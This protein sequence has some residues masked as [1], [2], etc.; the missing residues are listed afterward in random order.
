M[1]TKEEILTVINQLPKVDR[2]WIA[3]NIAKESTSSLS[4]MA[5]VRFCDV[6]REL[7][8]ETYYWTAKDAGCMNILLKKIRAKMIEAGSACEDNEV[9]NTME[10]YIRQAYKVDPWIADHYNVANLNSQFNNLYNK[11]KYGTQQANNNNRN[12]LAN[13]ARDLFGGR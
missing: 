3:A 5:K 1:M 7:T 8:N 4:G 6:Y 11:I 2:Q 12:A 9:A 10:Y 13:Y